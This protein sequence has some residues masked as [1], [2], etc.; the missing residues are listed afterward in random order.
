MCA[1]S[2]SVFNYICVY[3]RD[4]GEMSSQNYYVEKKDEKRRDIQRQHYQQQH[5]QQHCQQQFRYFIFTRLAVYGKSR[6][7][8]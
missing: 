7:T 2:Q 4:D 3:T 5:Q 8:R 6:I 1:V